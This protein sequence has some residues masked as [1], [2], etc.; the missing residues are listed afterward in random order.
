MKK[1]FLLAPPLIIPTQRFQSETFS[2]PNDNQKSKGAQF[3]SSY[4]GYSGPLQVTY[5]DEMYAGPQQPA[6]VDTIV[7]LTGITHCPDLNG[8]SPNCVSI[9]PVVWLELS[10]LFQCP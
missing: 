7:D 5:P 10:Q 6:F 3:T 1:V 4:H 9:T 8:G 2:A